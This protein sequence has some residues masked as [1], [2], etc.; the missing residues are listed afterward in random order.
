MKIKD[1]DNAMIHV[2]HSQEKPYMVSKKL[3][4]DKV[5]SP[6]CKIYLLMLQANCVDSVPSC[7]PEE[8]FDSFG[9]NTK[10]LWEEAIERGY[11]L[12]DS[13]SVIPNSFYL[14]NVAF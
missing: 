7:C 9:I 8:Y 14:D 2:R 5:L 13:D 1:F 11:I 6:A 4:K 10:V 12:F 3:V